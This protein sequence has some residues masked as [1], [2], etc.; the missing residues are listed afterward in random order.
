[1]VEVLVPRENVNDES[2]VILEVHFLSGSKVERGDVVVSIETSKTNIDVEAPGDG[3][4]EHQLK[5]GTEVNVGSF[6]FSL[7]KENELIS[8]VIEQSNIHSTES[9]LESQKSNAKFSLNAIKRAKELGVNLGKFDN[10]WVTSVDVER[11][12]GVETVRL[13]SRRS[14]SGDGILEK[15]KAPDLTVPFANIA[16]SK[17]KQVEAKNLVS[18][19]HGNTTSTIG[20]EI[21]LK[22]SRLITPPFIFK[23]GISDLVVFE[24]SKLLK[25]YPELNGS[26][27]D[28]KTW[29]KYE[30]VNFGWSFDNGKNLKVLA[31]KDADKLSLAGLQDQVG[32]LLDLYDSGETIP[33]ELLTDST[34]TFSDLSRSSASF[35]TPLINGRQTLILGI[36]RKSKYIF[37]V[38]ASFDHRVSEGLSVANF[39]GELR[40]RVSSYFLDQGGVVNLSCCVCGKLMTEELAL[41]HRG[42]IKITLANGEDESLCRNCFESW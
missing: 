10:S 4:I 11:Q 31:I 27:F 16:I 32:R 6:L 14:A 39:L 18:G 17:R 5:N 23:D 38:F 20:V 33:I 22:G 19:D 36:V 9:N 30:Q 1:M 28:E 41:G 8:N 25:Q 7:K 3:V 34:V 21:R 29:S 2:V 12:A 26:Y 35:M 37:E 40:S 24:A 15:K 13:M 42:F